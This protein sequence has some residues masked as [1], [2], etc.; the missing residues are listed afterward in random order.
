MNFS[1]PP[2]PNALPKEQEPI[3]NNVHPPPVT[4]ISN[5]RQPNTIITNVL[6]Q[7]MTYQPHSPTAK[8]NPQF[9]VNPI[10]DVPPIEDAIVFGIPNLNSLHKTISSSS[11][12]QNFN[13]PKDIISPNKFDALNSIEEQFQQNEDTQCSVENLGSTISGKSKAL[14]KGKHPQYSVASKKPA[15]GKQGKKHQQQL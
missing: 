1:R 5:L 8:S 9:D 6:G 2:A 12:S 14:E 15:M 10:G 13:Q 4:T 3:C 11:T 7:P